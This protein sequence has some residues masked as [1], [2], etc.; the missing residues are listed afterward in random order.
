MKKNLELDLKFFLFRGGVSSDS[1]DQDRWYRDRNGQES[2]ISPRDIFSFR[3]WY[4]TK[5]KICGQS[6]KG[7]RL[8]KRTR[9][10]YTGLNFY[11]SVLLTGGRVQR[12]VQD[13][14]QGLYYWKGL[15]TTSVMVPSAYAV[16]S[17]NHPVTCLLQPAPWSSNPT[18]QHF[19]LLSGHPG[20]G[21]LEDGMLT[22]PKPI[23]VW[24]AFLPAVV[25]HVTPSLSCPRMAY[26]CHL[27]YVTA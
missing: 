7:V 16:L 11:H 5:V 6:G 23:M 3:S 21:E 27:F 19:P 15:Q 1:T 10:E 26:I 17:N 25:C 8:G 18:F 20:R 2:M 4:K 12:G 22:N 9:M 13:R 14:S 24:T